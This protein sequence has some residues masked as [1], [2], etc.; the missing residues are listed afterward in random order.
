MVRISTFSAFLAFKSL[1]L[2]P[3]VLTCDDKLSTLTADEGFSVVACGAEA[4]AGLQSFPETD[5]NSAFSAF[6]S[7]TAASIWA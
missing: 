3:A 5:L 7:W 1:T 4:A 2:S 6:N